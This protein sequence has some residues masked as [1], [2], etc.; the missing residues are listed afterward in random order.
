MVKFIETKA[1]F[2]ALVADNKDKL[3]VVDFTASWCGPCKMIGPV[4][5][6]LAEEHSDVIFV[7]V[8]V[9]ANDE[10]AGACGISAMPTFHCYKNG[11][12]VEEMCGASEDKLKALVAK[13]K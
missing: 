13:H 7:K 5:E 10:T 1:E 2:D 3:I 9:D 12:K 8:D 11:Q 4:F 6:K